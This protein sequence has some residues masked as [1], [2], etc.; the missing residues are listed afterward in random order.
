LLGIVSVNN[1]EQIPRLVPGYSLPPYAY[2]PGLSPHP[3]RDPEGH[4]LKIKI[5]GNDT[6][7]SAQWEVCEPYLLGFDMFNHGFYWEAHEAWEALW[8]AIEREGRRATFLKGLIKLTASG[9]KARQGSKSGVKHLADGAI[10]EFRAV[11]SKN[12]NDCGN[13]MGLDLKALIDITE[14]VKA[15]D[16]NKAI[17]SGEHSPRVYDFI[18]LPK[19]KKSLD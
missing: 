11:E 5:E 17:V 18:L 19:L 2:T 9:V 10:K 7:T 12:Q 13:Y 3:T 16:I 15:L 6:F 14:K 4:K 8:Q 1:D